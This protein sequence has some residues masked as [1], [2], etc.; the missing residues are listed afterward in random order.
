MN[1]KLAGKTQIKS[2]SRRHAAE[3]AA[4]CF[5][6]RVIRI[7]LLAVGA[8]LLTAGIITGNFRDVFRKA[9]MIC[10]ECIGIG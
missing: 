5:N 1:K 7:L 10:F 8:V 6:R 9:S 4:L 2:N 3:F